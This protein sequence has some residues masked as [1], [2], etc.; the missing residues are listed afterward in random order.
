MDTFLSLLLLP[1]ILAAKQ[2]ADYLLRMMTEEIRPPSPSYSASD[3]VSAT[4]EQ[5]SLV[6][7]VTVSAPLHLPSPVARFVLT[8]W[9]ASHTDHQSHDSGISRRRCSAL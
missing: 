7:D 2:V 3:Q 4:A 1:L 5:F 6:V 8:E 9:L